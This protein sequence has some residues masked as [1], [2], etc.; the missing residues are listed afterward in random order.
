[1]AD[2]GIQFDPAVVP[3]LRTVFSDA[4]AKVDEQIRLA[5][6]NASVTPLW[7]SDPISEY[8]GY[9]I[10]TVSQDAMDSLRTYRDA[11]G[12]MVDKLTKAAGDYRESEEDK[13]VSMSQ[14]GQG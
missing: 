11:L 12:V 13:N 14:H 7:A 3:K 5:S 9:R 8:A 6:S 1:M 10:N 2:E 4:L